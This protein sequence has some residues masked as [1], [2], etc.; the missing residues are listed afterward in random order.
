M[1]RVG[2]PARNDTVIRP[3]QNATNRKMAIVHVRKASV[4]L[5]GIA[6]VHTARQHGAI[7]LKQQIISSNFTD[8]AIPGNS[9]V[10]PK[11]TNPR[12]VKREKISHVIS[13]A[14]GSS[15]GLEDRIYSQQDFLKLRRDYYK[16]QRQKGYITE[17][18]DRRSRYTVLRNLKVKVNNSVL[19][20]R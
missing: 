5:E 20:P 9:C 2:L 13:P 19:N 3:I 7:S 1:V 4:I 8:E 15:S 10:K 14:K 11:L 12:A 16:S 18:F 17:E 6:A